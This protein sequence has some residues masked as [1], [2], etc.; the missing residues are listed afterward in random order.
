MVGAAIVVVIAGCTPNDSADEAAGGEAAPAATAPIEENGQ[1]EESTTNDGAVESEPTLPDNVW[2][3]DSITFT[4]ED[5]ADPSDPANQDRIT[6]AV[7]ITRANSGGQIYNARREQR[8]NK[9]IS[10][11]GTPWAFG[12]TAEIESLDFRPFRMAVEE[13]KD[14]VGKPLVLYLEQDDIFI[15]VTFLAW[16]TEKRGGFSYQRSTP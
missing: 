5:G 14:V 2:A 13:P 10:P 4:K 9:G 6:E 11:A 12:T 16:S 1:G 7:W 15:D 8:P 3:G